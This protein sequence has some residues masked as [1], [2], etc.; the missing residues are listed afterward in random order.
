[1]RQPAS[2]TQL[3][4]EVPDLQSPHSEP[5]KNQPAG[6]IESIFVNGRET[7]IE[8]H[9][10][11]KKK[12]KNYFRK[13]CLKYKNNP[14]V[15]NCFLFS[16]CLV[17]SFSI[18]AS[19]LLF[20]PLQISPWHHLTHQLSVTSVFLSADSPP[21]TSTCSF[22]QSLS[23]FRPACSVSLCLIGGFPTCLAV[24]RYLF[25]CEADWNM[26]VGKGQ[27]LRQCGL[28]CTMIEQGLSRVFWGLCLLM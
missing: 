21:G 22:T 24:L 11:S 12:K 5:T 13:F 9:P 19:Y 17:V 20:P 3:V 28:T 2:V 15:N 25:S 26:G 18:M 8:H 16:F 7:Q 4:G 23:P 27:R 14:A 6:T 1:M 10:F